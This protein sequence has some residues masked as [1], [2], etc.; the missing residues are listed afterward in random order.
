MLTYNN[1]PFISGRNG[2][3]MTVTGKQKSA[4]QK[5]MHLINILNKKIP[6]LYT[7]NLPV[8]SL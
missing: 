2:I 1:S 8:V 7:R 6:G 4:Y 3:L 5:Y